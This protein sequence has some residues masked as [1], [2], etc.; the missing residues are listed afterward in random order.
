MTGV[1]R[2]HR[3]RGIAL[4]LKE[5]Q[6]AAAKAAGYQTL[7]TQ[8]DLG[9]APMRRVNDKLGYVLRYEWVHMTGPLR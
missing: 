3:G 1:A 2:S 8:N 6:V 9:N 7:R 4:A 5:T